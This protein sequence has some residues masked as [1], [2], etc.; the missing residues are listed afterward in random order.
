[1]F[2]L[3]AVSG[4]AHGTTVTVLEFV[5]HVRGHTDI[6]FSG[7]LRFN[8]GL[9]DQDPFPGYGFYEPLRP[10]HVTLESGQ[11]GVP[12]YLALWS[13]SS[14]RIDVQDDVSVPSGDFFEVTIGGRPLTMP[15]WTPGYFFSRS[16]V[17]SLRNIGRR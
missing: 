7:T 14:G 10:G 12:N 16:S 11:P 6:F 2:A 15:A 17:A 5:G 9:Q 3:L 8:S 13:G 1:M 4:A